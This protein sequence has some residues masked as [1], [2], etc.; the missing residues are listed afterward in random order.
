LSFTLEA[1]PVPGSYTPN[2]AAAAV[3][4]LAANRD[5]YDLAILTLT[6]TSP[7][8][9]ATLSY[10][11]PTS[12]VIGTFAGY[13]LQLT[14][15]GDFRGQGTRLAATN[16]LEGRRRG[17]IESDFDS[18][19]GNTTT[20]GEP[21]PLPL[22]G[23]TAS[24]DSGGP[25]FADFGQGP[26]LIGVLWGGYNPYGRDSA[27]GDISQWILLGMPE[28]ERF[29]AS[30]VLFTPEPS[31]AILTLLSIVLFLEFRRR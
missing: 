8:A 23:S 15:E 5:D 20:F 4:P 10:R 28:T 17:W 13:G 16:R 31:F 19:D 30:T 25:L 7:V 3:H 1:D 24:G 12:G 11:E 29:I 27:Y 21:F 14:G 22:E 6:Y 18:S 2:V 26:L 9:P